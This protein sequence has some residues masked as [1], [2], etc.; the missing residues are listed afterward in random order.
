M[1]QNMTLITTWLLTDN[2]IRT[3]GLGALLV[4]SVLAMLNPDVA[5]VA[6]PSSGNSR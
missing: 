6:G 4:L 2:R 1:K 5:A 3:L